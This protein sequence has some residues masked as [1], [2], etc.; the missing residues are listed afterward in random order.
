MEFEKALGL[1]VISSWEDVVNST[2]KDCAIH[3]EYPNLIGTPVESL[4]VWTVKRGHWRLVCDYST[5]LSQTFPVPGVHFENSFHSDTLA[6]NLAFIMEHQGQLTRRD[7]SVNGMVQVSLPDGEDR[8]RA[9]AW[10]AAMT[11]NLGTRAGE[12]M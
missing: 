5:T 6:R 1:A 8:A 9:A 4:K 7:S 3:V 10:S 2:D 11:T 12:P